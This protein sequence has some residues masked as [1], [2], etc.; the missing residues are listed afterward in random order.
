[1]TKILCVLIGGVMTLTNPAWA[2][3][4]GAGPDIAFLNSGK[5]VPTTLPFSE[6]VQVNGTLYLS[7]QLGNIP[8][9]MK[10]VSGG[11]KQEA[12]QTMDNIKTVLEAHGY[13]LRNLVK[14]TV[15]LAD[16]SEWSAFNEVYQSYFKDQF[17]AR[18]AFATNGLALGARVEVD[19]I[20]T[21][22]PNPE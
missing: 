1:M 15:M 8:G 21:S 22:R 14:C 12:R 9:T 17:P 20:A 18:S 7:G 16:I 2:Q 19:C 3:K 10:L 13:G 6:A 4:S 5:I 11:I